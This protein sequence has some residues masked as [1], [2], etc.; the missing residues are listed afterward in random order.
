MILSGV[1]CYYKEGIDGVKIGV[2]KEFVGGVKGGRGNGKRGGKYG[3]RLKGEEV[4]ERK[5][6]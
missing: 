6:F 1:G 4:G 2:E 3:W 5:G